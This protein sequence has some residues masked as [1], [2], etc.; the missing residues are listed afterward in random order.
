MVQ[1][2]FTEI[3]KPT[4]S[5]D[6][7]WQVLT[8]CRFLKQLKL[9]V[10]LNKVID[11]C[12]SLEFVDVSNKEVFH[13]TLRA[14]LV[15]SY[16]DIAI[17]DRAFSMFWQKP[18]DEEELLSSCCGDSEANAGQ[19]DG[20]SQAETI[21]KLLE[22]FVE[23]WADDVQSDDLDEQS[24]K[25]WSPD[26]TLAVKDFSAYNDEDLKA[27]R[28][29]IA[30]LAPRL[31]TRLSRRNQPHH[32]GHTVDPR[33]TLR[34]N[35]KYAG[36]II[37]LR[38]K[39]RKITKTKLVLLCDVSG[40]MDCYSKFLIQFI[41]ALQNQLKGIETFVFS[42]RLSRITNMLRTR[43]IYEAL[44]RVALAVTDWSGGTTIGDC[45]RTFNEGAAK[46][47]L[48]KKSLVV[49]ISDGWDRGDCETLAREMRRL[50]ARSYKVIWLNPLAGSPHYQP[51][52]SGMKAAMPHVDYFLPAHNLQSLMTLSKL[53]VAIS[54]K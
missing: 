52:C 32:D 26:E 29:A 22:L 53:L 38:H 14:N 33:R 48:G 42:T 39:K 7:L 28:S 24:I 19:G 50:S 10:T 11:T 5:K 44:A 12:R 1:E 4:I 3:T 45:L 20:Q 51:I 27:I 40:S 35:I 8:F 30:R 6:M 21:E 43:H 46:S 18:P 25:G 47:I 54:K 49:L 17:F 37:E 36:D 9:D 31:A 23:D 34:C 16:E 41:Y 13:L 15:S 2:L